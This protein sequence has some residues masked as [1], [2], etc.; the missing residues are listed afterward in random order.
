MNVQRQVQAKPNAG[1]NVGSS[2]GLVLQR[3]CAC[4]GTPGPTGECASCKKKREASTGA[5]ALQKQSLTIGDPRDALEQEADRVADAIVGGKH[6][7][8]PSGISFASIPA[9]RMQREDAPK[10]KSNEEKYVDAAKKVGEAFL[11]TPLGKELKDKLLNDPLVKGAKE[12]AEGFIATLSGKIITGTVAAGTITALAATHKSLPIAIPEIPLDMIKPG[13]KVQ[14]TYE[15]PVDQPT[16]AMV[17]FSYEFGAGDK[18]SKPATSESEQFRAETARMAAEQE[19]FR[20][21]LKSP[22]EKRLERDAMMRWSQQRLGLPTNPFRLPGLQPRQGTDAPKKK[23]DTPTVRRKATSET[24]SS[25]DAPPIVNEVLQSTGQPL[26]AETRAY[27]EPRFAHDFSGVRVHTDAKAAESARAV[28]ANAYAVGRNIVF[29]AG[30]FDPAGLEGRRLIAHELT[31]VV[32]QGGSGKKKNTDGLIPDQTLSR[33]FLH[34]NDSESLD[35]PVLQR[36]PSSMSAISQ[37]ERARLKINVTPITIGQSIINEVFTLNARGNPGT[38]YNPTGGVMS[39]GSNIA[40]NLNRGL[41]SIGGY[42][43]NQTNSLPLNSTIN[44]SLDLTAFSGPNGIFRFTWF[45]HTENRVTS[46]VML[47]ELIGTTAPI[48]TVNVVPSGTFSVS[49][50]SFRLGGTWTNGEFGQLQHALGLM[51]ASALTD[52]DGL[53]F[54]RLGGSPTIEA[55]H[56]D[57]TSDTVELYDNAFPNAS[58]RLGNVEIGELTVLHE[59]GHALDLRKLERAWRTFDS[60]GQTRAGQRTLLSTRSESGS[61]YVSTPNSF[62]VD[63]NL[64][65]SAATDGDFRRAVR[66][67]GV[68]LDTTRRTLATG[69]TAKLNHGITD[70]SDTDF[71]EL[72]AESFAMFVADPNTLQLLRPAT[73]RFFDNRFQP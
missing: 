39:F 64:Q 24:T 9:S 71:Q 36:Q 19:K 35:K 54:R 41:Q 47:I 31:H 18:K 22:D 15:G 4:G 11:Q 2:T 29:G 60:G 55:G 8:Q 12:T 28:N 59:V 67:D 33:G 13:L 27:F 6:T 49:G 23:E 65:R 42:L 38:T 52:A 46:N 63:L 21:G 72:F 73:F 62:D 10:E 53:T 50:H 17:S 66:T 57:Q 69:G 34:L 44:V 68:R 7:A 16:K 32:Q 40:G 56:Y 61:R 14:L 51:R 70:Y 5:G 26:N 20:E 58:L 45:E 30:R 1:S 48:Q 37:Q 3:K 43:Q 25:S